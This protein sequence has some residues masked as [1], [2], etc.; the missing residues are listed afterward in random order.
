MSEIPW[1]LGKTVAADPG[2]NGD[3]TLE[4]S[5]NTFHRMQMREMEP[6]HVLVSHGKPSNPNRREARIRRFFRRL[7][8]SSRA[9]E[10]RDL[11]GVRSDLPDTV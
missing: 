4:A 1:F 5:R 2:P 6:A 11:R 7:T 3:A 9:A 8:N 10:P